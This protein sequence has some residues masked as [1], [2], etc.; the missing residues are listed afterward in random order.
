MSTLAARSTQ[1][2][3]GVNKWQEFKKMLEAS[4]R[5]RQAGTQTRV[6]A[7]QEIS[8]VEGEKGP[9]SEAREPL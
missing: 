5:V 4:S 8:Q 7:V 9:K 3:S 1:G 2:L 6:A